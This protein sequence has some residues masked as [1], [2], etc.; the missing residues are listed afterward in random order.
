MSNTIGI[1]GS[2]NIG[3]A[4]ATHLSKTNYRV[5]ITN[6]RGPE[7]LQDLVASIGGSLTAASLKE[8]IKQSDVLFLAIPWTHVTDLA[9][10]FAAYSGKII[11]DATNNYVSVNPFKLADL[12]GKTTGEYAANLFPA[13]RIV[14]AFNTLAAATLAQSPNSSQ[15]NTVIFIS[16]NDPDA[17]K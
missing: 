3:R 9:E 16:S 11:V 5:L 6:S 13:Q 12:G 15:G 1:I 8:T 4:L 14:K 2:G 7:S 10:E 17:K